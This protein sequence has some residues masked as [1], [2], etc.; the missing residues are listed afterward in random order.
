[1]QFAQ[2]DFV[3]V[4]QPIKRND[5][6]CFFFSLFGT[7]IPAHVVTSIKGLLYIASILLRSLEVKY[8]ANE[9]VL[10]GNLS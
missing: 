2:L 9:S 4:Q 10:K 3:V 5:V 1:M 8:S 7:V 6:H